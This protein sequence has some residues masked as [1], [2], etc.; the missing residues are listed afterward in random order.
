MIEL[1]FSLLLSVPDADKKYEYCPK[2]GV[3]KPVHAV[4]Y[5]T[6]LIRSGI[7]AQ[8]PVFTE[9][10]SCRLNLKLSPAGYVIS[11]SAV[12]CADKHF[13]GILKAIAAASP[14][15]VLPEAYS[16]VHDINLTISG[17]PPIS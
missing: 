8:M 5:N 17:L 6:A 1:I 13:A 12:S 7:L 2:R 15:P 14:L 9:T 16:Q 10:F 3:C 11:V 4:Q